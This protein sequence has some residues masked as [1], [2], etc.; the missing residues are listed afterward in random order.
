MSRV[1]LCK[2]LVNRGKLVMFETVFEIGLSLSSQAIDRHGGQAMVQLNRVMRRLVL[3]PIW[4]GPPASGVSGYEGVSATTNKAR[5]ESEGK[6]VCRQK[7][8]DG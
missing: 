6:P 3:V 4:K 5:V 2:I 8:L 1:F 7:F